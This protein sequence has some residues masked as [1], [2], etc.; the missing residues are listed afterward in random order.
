[1]NANQHWEVTEPCRITGENAAGDTVVE[2]LITNTD[3][4]WGVGEIYEPR[5]L[6]FNVNSEGLLTTDAGVTNTN[7]FRSPRRNTFN[8]AFHSWLSVTHP[9]VYNEMDP[10]SISSSGPGFA[11]QNPDHMLI[12]VDYVQ[13]FVAQSDDYPLDPTGS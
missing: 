12:A 11:T 3:D 10:G 13:E 5:D 2:C 6:R 9:N 4:F 8:H 7:T 1:M